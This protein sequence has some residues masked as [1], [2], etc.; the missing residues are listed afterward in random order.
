MGWV[1]ATDTFVGDL[2]GMPVR[3]AA[4]EAKS[5]LDPVVKAWPGLFTPLEEP[6]AEPAAEDAPKRSTTPKGKP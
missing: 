2:D 4:G 6:A 5:D 1:K 3:V